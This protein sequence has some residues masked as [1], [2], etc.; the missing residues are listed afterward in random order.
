MTYAL[1]YLSQLTN[2]LDKEDVIEIATKSS[3]K[4]KKIGITGFLTCRGG[5][6][7]QYLEGEK[8]PLDRLMSIIADDCRHT[9]QHTIYLS[10][11][12]SHFSEWSM[13]YI[14][15]DDLTRLTMD[16]SLI[17]TIEHLA[18]ENYEQ[19]LVEAQIYTII[20][21]ISRILYLPRLD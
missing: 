16:D 17:S 21:R 10:T 3:S 12:I 14:S 1:I 6:F 5:K 18:S 7:V 13:R 20:N 9:V 11:P 15:S 19:K 4:N 2:P 8:E